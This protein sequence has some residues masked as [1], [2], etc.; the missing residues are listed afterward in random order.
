MSFLISSPGSIR[1]PGIE[2]HQE[3]RRPDV[4]AGVPRPRVS[5]RPVV[6]GKFLAAGGEKWYVRG[7]TYG[8]FGPDGSAGEYG[9]AAAVERDFAMMAAAGIN[10]VRVYTVPRRWLLDLAASHGLRVMV[11]LPWEQHVAFL[12]DVRRAGDIEQRVRR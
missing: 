10:A 5:S 3:L 7:V 1:P 9:E 11:G 4:A 12:D 2:R 6:A 8:P